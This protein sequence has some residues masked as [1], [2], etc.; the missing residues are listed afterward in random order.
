MTSHDP[1]PEPTFGAQ[2]IDALKRRSTTVMGRF[3][4]AQ[5]QELKAASRED[6]AL[7]FRGLGY[8]AV[9]RAKSDSPEELADYLAQRDHQDR[10]VVAAMMW[11]IL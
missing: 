4:Y 3:N 8:H 6:V 1:E 10:V 7:L 11:G 5:I 2:L 9:Q